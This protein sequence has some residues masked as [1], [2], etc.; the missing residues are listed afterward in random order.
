MK[1][2]RVNRARGISLL[3]L[4]DRLVNDRAARSADDDDDIAECLIRP[5]S[6]TPWR[7]LSV[8]RGLH[9]LGPAQIIC[10]GLMRVSAGCGSLRLAKICA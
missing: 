4:R 2:G 9:A 10:P 1:T 7:E 5:L 8:C 6:L 3:S